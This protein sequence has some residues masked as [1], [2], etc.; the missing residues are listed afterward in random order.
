MSTCARLAQT[1][2][3]AAFRTNALV[4]SDSC[5]VRPYARCEPMRNSTPAVLKIKWTVHS[6]TRLWPST[7]TCLLLRGQQREYAFQQDLHLA[8]FQD[9]L[10]W[11]RARARCHL[12]KR[13]PHAAACLLVVLPRTVL[14]DQAKLTDVGTRC[15]LVWCKGKSPTVC[16][17]L[18]RSAKPCPGCMAGAPCPDSLYSDTAVLPTNT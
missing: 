14:G 7:N 10:E 11:Q 18:A 8:P 4:F 16:P 1:S 6:L 9:R 12:I 17:C 15:L 3:L 13:L 2:Q 5:P